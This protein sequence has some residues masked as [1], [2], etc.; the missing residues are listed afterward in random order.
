LA[1]EAASPSL[2]RNVAAACIVYA[3]LI[4]TLSVFAR[5]RGPALPQFVTVFATGMFLTEICTFL[6]LLALARSSRSRSVILLACAY[7]YSG[8]MALLHLLTFPGALLPGGAAVLGGPQTAGWLYLA[9]R[10]GFAF[11]LIAAV[12]AEAV[13]ARIAPLAAERV[14][15][16]AAIATVAVL[17]VV[18]ALLMLTVAGHDL[19]PPQIV[20]GNRFAP[21]SI[22]ATWVSVVAA[23][24]AF[25]LA[26]VV[27]RGRKL[28]FLWLS[29]ALLGFAGDV[30]VTT[31]SG[32]RY[33]LGFYT[34]RASGL[35]AGS[36]LFV[37]FLVRF[38]RQNRLLADEIARREEAESSILQMQKLEAVGQLTGGL[39]HDFNNLLSA[40]IGSL[41]L[42]ELRADSASD[43][44]TGKLLGAARRA[45]LRG[46]KLTHEL[47]AFARKQDLR[48][49]PVDLNDVVR[50]AGDLLARSVGP[51]IRIEEALAPDLWPALAD[52]SQMQLVILN[53]AINARDA[54]ASGGTITVSTRNVAAGD[55]LSPPDLPA[56]D[57]VMLT[58]S[59]VGMGMNPDVLAKCF[60]PFFTTKD[61][62]KGSG[63]GLSMVLGVAKQSGGTVEIRSEVGH[64]TAVR[65]YLSRGKATSEQVQPARA[66][67]KTGLPSIGALVLL[68]D[69]DVEVRQITAEQLR[70]L[71]CAVIEAPSGQVAL[72]LLNRPETPAVDLLISDYAMPEMTGI[73]LARKARDAR[74]DLPVVLM[75][76]YAEERLETALSG[77][78]RWLSKPFRV[79]D[80]RRAV[81]QALGRQD[82]AADPSNIVRLPARSA[83]ARDLPA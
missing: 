17:A 5:V 68:V 75:T 22:T 45:A 14:G 48:I 79:N 82:E 16:T 29:M 64:G 39:A 67:V 71:G 19:L 33:T 36:I 10:L 52:A 65:V 63:L 35:L 51:L 44:S 54:M 47:L 6:L 9:W 69:D 37:V 3:A 40:I 7:L 62:G 41:D 27:T 61:V 34:G 28:L 30:F 80:L 26:W 1:E 13:S 4:V 78:W 32:G 25:V 8:L 43:P 76:G 15:R 60:E 21:W 23:G 57:Y 58:V 46:A 83:D 74:A 2:R 81:M 11:L 20:E 12:L 66:G 38:A 31:F 72:D 70:A 73:D 42:L 53:L 59:D 50:D 55:P 18:A 24:T 56:G 77:D 49:E